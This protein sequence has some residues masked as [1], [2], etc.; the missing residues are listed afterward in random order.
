MDTIMPYARL[1]Y[2][3]L[4]TARRIEQTVVKLL[5]ES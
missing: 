3:Y 2:D 1:E 4:P 5:E